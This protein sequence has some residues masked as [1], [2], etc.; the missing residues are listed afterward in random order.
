MSSCWCCNCA[1]CCWM[2]N[3]CLSHRFCIGSSSRRN[4][5]S[6]M[7]CSTRS[8]WVEE[9][10][11]LHD[12]IGAFH[13]FD[14]LHHDAILLHSTS[15]DNALFSGEDQNDVFAARCC[16]FD[17]G[18]SFAFELAVDGADLEYTESSSPSDSICEHRKLRSAYC[19]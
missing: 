18:K 4:R 7:L 11:R 10:G 12:G 2:S 8:S 5:S 17:V 13:L 6:M 9:A 3:S 14:L 19:A 16:V 15:F 1:R